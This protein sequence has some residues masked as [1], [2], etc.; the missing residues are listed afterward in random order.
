MKPRLILAGPGTGKTTR[1]AQ[2]I[3]ALLNDPKKNRASIT[4]LT[5]SNAA[6]T[7]MV[8]RL[9]KEG[10]EKDAQ[11]TIRTLHSLAK[12]ILHEKGHIVELRDDFRV[13]D[14]IEE[15]FILE[16]VC[17][18]LEINKWRAKRLH[19]AYDE[20]KTRGVPATGTFQNGVQITDA[21]WEPFYNRYTTL[22]RLYNA[23]DW[24]DVIHLVNLVF[25]KIPNLARPYV[26]ECQ[27]LLVDEYQDLNASDRRLIQTLAGTSEGLL[28]VGDD[29]QSIYE[30]A[31]FAD[32]KGV[33][34]FNVDYPTAEVEELNVCYRCPGEILKPALELIQHNN[35]D[36]VDKKIYAC[37]D[38]PE[39]S[40]IKLSCKSAKEEKE[41]L[42]SLIMER[43]SQGMSPDEIIVL[44]SK[45]D[46]AREYGEYFEKCGI[47][48]EICFEEK[49]E[50]KNSIR[51]KLLVFI[52]A[53]R[54]QNDGLAI[55][56]CLYYISLSADAIQKLRGIA[57]IENKDLWGAAC[58]AADNPKKFG[59]RFRGIDK[60]A[61]LIGTISHLSGIPDVKEVIEQ[62][63][64]VFNFDIEEAKHFMENLQG[65]D[66][67]E[68]IEA[69]WK[70]T[71]IIEEDT[72]I[73]N[74]VRFMTMHGAKG[75][76]ANLVIV[77]ALEDEFFP[78]I[79]QNIQEQ[80][81]LLYVSMTRAKRE[82]IL[83]YAWSR[84]GHTRYMRSNPQLTGRKPSRFLDEIPGSVYK[85]KGP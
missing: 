42:A 17:L 13:A 29:D 30:S 68:I 38:T 59:I 73:T 57:F 9:K 71:E 61:D 27:N 23:V 66:L 49:E 84:R 7:E 39:G 74:A 80:R 20:L 62:A 69:L 79:S 34:N 77:S 54:N 8:D 65:H 32:P 64:R 46:L 18:D 76:A 22:L 81:R 14:Q 82:L 41:F 47:P 58:L 63:A 70:D 25:E 56:Q 48:I 24:W 72:I 4:A 36:R 83:S 19:K 10:I 6:T 53:I 2:E 45:R 26:H 50:I 51:R 3:I 28:C 85:P 60:L 31:R 55:R 37:E 40:L 12:K 33:V 21:D 15:S 16:D 5:F 43:L 35:P 67:D 78:G 52:R 11:P 1:I 75:L 44:F